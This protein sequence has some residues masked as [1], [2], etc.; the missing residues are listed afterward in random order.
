MMEL[1]AGMPAMPLNYS[2]T[3]VRDITSLNLGFSIC[4]MG[5][6]TVLSQGFAKNVYP[7]LGDVPG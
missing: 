2:V 1:G 6:R 4:E 3:L 7:S 5:M